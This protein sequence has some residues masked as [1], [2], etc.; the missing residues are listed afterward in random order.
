MAVFG[1]IAFFVLII[2]CVNFMNLSTARSLG[3]AREVGV[4]KAL[5]G[6][7]AEIRGQFL[8]ES[9]AISGLALALAVGLMAATLPLFCTLAGRQLALSS[10]W[11][12]A[13]LLGFLALWVFVA[14]VSGSYPAFFLAGIHPVTVFRQRVAV[15]STTRGLRDALV[16]LQFLLSVVLA[17]GALVVQHQWRY[18]QKRDLGYNRAQLLY[19]ENGAALGNRTLA[20]KAQLQSLPEVQSVSLSQLLPVGD[21]KYVDVMCPEGRY[22]QD[23]TPVTR[24][25]V[26]ADF[27]ETYGMSLL[28]GRFFSAD[29]GAEAN[30]AVVNESAVR[31]FGWEQALGMR[32]FDGQPPHMDVYTVIGVVKDFH[33]ESMRSPIAPL[34]MISGDASEFITVRLAPGQI[35]DGVAAVREL[36]EDFVPSR[37]FNYGFVDQQFDALYRN[38]RREGQIFALFAGLAVF[39]GSLGLLGLVAF[40]AEQRTK[41][42]GIRKV[43]GAS[44]GSVI[45]LLGREFGRLVLL[46]FA[47]GA[48]LAY[49]LMRRW[50]DGFSYRVPLTVF[51]F[52]LAGLL[53][54][55][56]AGMTIT[57]LAVRAARMN[58]VKSLRHE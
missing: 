51:P 1:I 54:A 58:P 28:S 40:A 12:G 42:I 50:L 55:G 10:L 14:L 22:R 39:I 5:G 41:E 44:A 48:P 46:A 32:I 37:L 9:L 53:A 26:D 25:A 4:R 16:V 21:N 29:H 7:Q 43:L 11:D 38:E 18:I 35:H 3:R 56:V 52:L 20:F 36:W 19:I 13:T 31:F 27:Q 30:N 47:L 8:S 45:V 34:A 6:Q 49:G 57:V 17:A 23:G 24:W 2:A 15:R 33:Y